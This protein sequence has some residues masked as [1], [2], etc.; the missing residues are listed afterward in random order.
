MGRRPPRW[1]GGLRSGPARRDVLGGAPAHGRPRR[2]A[3]PPGRA[4]PLRP[5]RGQRG[6][7]GPRRAGGTS[8]C[9]SPGP[10][11]PTPRCWRSIRPG[12]GR[13]AGAAHVP[14]PGPSRLVA[15]D[16]ERWLRRMAEVLPRIHAA[17][18]PPP[19]VI[20]PFAPYAQTSYEPPAWARHPKVWEQAAEIST[21]PRPSCPRFWSNA[22]FTPATFCGG[23]ARVGGR[24]LA[25]DQ[26]RPGR[27][28][29][30]ALPGEPA[31][32]R[33]RPADR[34]TALWEQAAGALSPLGRCRHRHRLPRRP[35]RR[36]GI[37]AP[38]GRGHAA[39]AVAELGGTSR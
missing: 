39:R 24:R 31:H 38:P 17:P 9:A 1:P 16:M 29:R 18:L 6:R 19:G 28:R 3:A 32:L 34:F 14:P 30:R 37:R 4:A 20:R 26:H 36:L 23:G 15:Q 7:T 8:T 33:R 5:P 12:R 10:E 13:G 27:G 2:R 11:V 21:G 35:A 25:G 22:T